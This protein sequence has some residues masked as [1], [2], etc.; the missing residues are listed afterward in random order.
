M[1]R[2]H[3]WKTLTVSVDKIFRAF[4][5]DIVS[6]AGRLH[7]SE[8]VIVRDNNKQLA[9]VF[10]VPEDDNKYR[11]SYLSLIRSMIDSWIR[12]LAL[13]ETI[14]NTLIRHLVLSETTGLSK[15]SYLPPTATSADPCASIPI[16]I[17]ARAKPRPTRGRWS[18]PFA[19]SPQSP[20]PT[21]VAPR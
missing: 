11:H 7:P 6:G 18:A 3:A 14:L 19:R 16:Y 12:Y 20:A 1:E 17:G 4:G 2:L 10:N 21:A 13:S 5:G 8:G 15:S 9:Q